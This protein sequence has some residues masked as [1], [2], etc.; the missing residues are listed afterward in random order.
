MLTNKYKA[1]CAGIIT[2]LSTEILANFDDKQK[3]EIG[4]VVHD[5]LIEHPEV[6]AQA[7]HTLQAKEAKIWIE[8]AKK[9]IIENMDAMFN[10][11]SPAIGS[12]KPKITIVEFFDYN[13]PHCKTMHSILEKLIAEN[14]DIKLVYKE[15]P[16]L[17]EPSL[18]ASR[19]ALAA[20]LQ[21]KYN[22]FHQ[23]LMTSPG[24]LT[25]QIVLQIAKDSALDL[26]KL[27]NDMN[28]PKIIQ[29]LQANQ[30]LAVALGMRGTPTFVIG[31]APFTKDM[32]VDFVPGET[33]QE[34]LMNRINAVKK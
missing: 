13:C 14:Q 25:D 32:Q 27:K 19:A 20:Q 2:L 10:S 6:I 26:E 30:K 34:D 28:S 15:L 33:T 7:I 1:F 24:P 5:Y 23:K 3:E 11:D 12:D 29:E 9:A 22:E 16:V 31:R 17:G 18:L 8:K 4:T 21:N